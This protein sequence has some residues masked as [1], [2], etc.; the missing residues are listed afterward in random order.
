MKTLGVSEKQIIKLEISA[1]ILKKN[2]FNTLKQHYFF[3]FIYSF[4]GV[5]YFWVK[6]CIFSPSC[7][8]QPGN[9]CFT[10]WMRYVTSWQGPSNHAPLLWE[11][12]L[13]VLW[14]TL[15]CGELS[16]TCR[17]I[18]KNFS[19]DFF[20]KEKIIFPALNDNPNNFENN[21]MIRLVVSGMFLLPYSAL[22][23]SFSSF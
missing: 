22:I 20:K 11:L 13:L 16:K 5:W 8:L 17:R 23:M 9:S 1:N 18:S 3:N 10:S 21:R 14:F 15:N 6:L 2:F 19:F 4:E 12:L 7:S